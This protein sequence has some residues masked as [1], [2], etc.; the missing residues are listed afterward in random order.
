LHTRDYQLAELVDVACLG[1]GDYVVG[2][3]DGLGL[4][5]ALMSRRSLA[6]WAALPTSVWMRMYAVTTDPDLLAACRPRRPAETGA[7]AIVA[8]RSRSGDHTAPGWS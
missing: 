5:D 4:L 3:G 2:A 1:A 6:T 7:E 8:C